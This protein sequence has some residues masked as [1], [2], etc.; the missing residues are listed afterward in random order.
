M[1]RQGDTTKRLAICRRLFAGRYTHTD[2]CTHTHMHTHT[3]THTRTHARTRTHA[4]THMHTHTCTHMHAC[5]HAHTHVHT[6]AHTHTRARAHTHTHR[7]ASVPYGVRG[8]AGCVCGS[9][10]HP[11]SPALAALGS[12]L[13]PVGCVVFPP[14]PGL[15]HGRGLGSRAHFSFGR[16]EPARWVA[17]TRPCAS[18]QPRSPRR[19]RGAGPAGR[20]HL[21]VAGGLEALVLPRPGPARPGVKCQR[22]VSAAATR[23]ALGGGGGGAM[24]WWCSGPSRRPARRA[25]S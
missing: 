24:R 19:A 20:R 11:A 7:T 4:H 22:G 16:R 10:L 17:R 1:T 21:A 8:G 3:H 6:C 18:A 2:A 14:R 23:A 12:P 13:S 9:P 25:L 5:M 15:A